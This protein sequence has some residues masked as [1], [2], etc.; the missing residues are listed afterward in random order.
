MAVPSV[1]F[2]TET[3]G[4][5]AADNIPD[6][7]CVCVYDPATNEYHRFYEK[8]GGAMRSETVAKACK[9]LLTCGKQVCGFNSTAY[10]LRL[11]AHHCNDT[12][13]KGDLAELAFTHID[14]ILN[15]WSRTGY[16]T[17]LQSMASGIKCGNKLMAGQD[18]VEAWRQGNLEQVLAYCDADCKLLA[19]VHDYATT[20][21]RLT[22]LNKQNKLQSVALD[23]Y[24]L[25]D[26]MSCLNAL[27]ELDTSWMSTPI[28]PDYE[29]AV[30]ALSP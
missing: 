3:S 23:G 14:I 10:D 12:K 17:S 30:N 15:F 27:A 18:A 2:D 19:D 8:E 13:L 5:F 1:F 20:Y 16:P 29:W 11:L 4:L 7:H 6:L 28:V 9:H 21:G 26:T 22:R 24:T 25:E